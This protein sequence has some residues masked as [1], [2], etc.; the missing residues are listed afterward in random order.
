VVGHQYFEELSAAASLGEISGAELA[1][2]KEH[3]AGCAS[4]RET[5]AQF[6]LHL[7][8]VRTAS[9]MAT[10]AMNGDE[11]IGNIDSARFR[12]TFLE[13]AAAEGMVFSD[14]TASSNLEI[15]HRQ[16]F[17][18]R[19]R[20]AFALTAAACLL[21]ARV[22]V[23]YYWKSREV[24]RSTETHTTTNGTMSIPS[25]AVNATELGAITRLESQNREL[26]SEIASLKVSLAEQTKTANDLNL[27]SV[28]IGERAR[29]TRAGT[30]SARVQNRRT[31]TSNLSIPD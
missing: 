4:C 11:A 3:M 24:T 14:R 25:D 21:I 15:P 16:H 10:A 1:E 7:S 28:A 27:D 26:V 17:K 9:R 6:F 19:W 20:F 29:G 2:L 5:Y 31:G 13:R 23:G 30:E 8:G 22:T 18:N 12:K